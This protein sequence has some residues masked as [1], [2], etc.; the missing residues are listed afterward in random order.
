MV[1]ATILRTEGESQMKWMLPGLILLATSGVAAQQ[2]ALPRP[3]AL[4]R[5]DAVARA[6]ARNPELEVAREQAAQARARI[7]EAAA[8]PDLDVTADWTGLS[9]PFRVGSGTGSDYGVGVTVPFPQKFLL[10]SRVAGAEY[11]SF[12]AAYEQLRQATASATIQAYDALL[13]AL[14]HQDDLL[15]G[16]SLAR[17]FLRKTEL[18][19][20]A[21]TVARI[22][23]LKAKVALAQSENQLIASERDISNARAGLNRQ[24]GRLLGAP[25]QPTDTLAVPPGP[26]DLDSLITVARTERPEVRGLA[27][28][29]QGAGAAAS[30]AQQYFLP[31]LSLGVS[32]NLVQGAADSYTFQVGFSLPLLFWNHQR[33]EVAEA[34]HR[35]RELDAAALDLLAQVEQDVRTAWAAADAAVKQAVYIRD[36]LLPEAREAYRI[37]SVNYALGGASSLDVLD[38]KRDLLDAQSQYTDALGAANDAVAQ[39]A[40]A[41]GD[42]PADTTGAPD[43]R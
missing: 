39:L 8:F 25:L 3:L 1:F 34:R 4:T 10:R 12:S 19:F 35:E 33:G 17:D 15:Q 23:V 18:R 41:A 26:G 14:R 38:A 24:L 37:V 30:L 21:G 22:D 28:L 9:G 5:A 36:A 27:S 16:D 11:R 13:T 42:T 7:T 32:K 29:R 2:P 31:D 6:L 20:T 43:A 40:L